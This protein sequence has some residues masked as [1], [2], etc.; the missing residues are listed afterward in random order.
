M[1]Q[2]D[3][4]LEFSE[5]CID[6]NKHNHVTTTY[7]LL[8]KKYLESGGKSLYDINSPD[9]DSETIIPKI[10]KKKSFNFYMI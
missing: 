2:F 4:N 6:A 3:F 7:Y 1:Q 9:F 10:S 5:K 8:L